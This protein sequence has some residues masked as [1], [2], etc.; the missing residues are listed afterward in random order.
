MTGLLYARCRRAGRG[1]LPPEGERRGRVDVD[2][3]H[4]GLE[5]VARGVAAEPHQPGVPVCTACTERNRREDRPLPPVT[6]SRTRVVPATVGVPLSRP[7]PDSDIPVGSWPETTL[8]D[9]GPTPWAVSG[10]EYAEPT[11]ASGTTRSVDHR[12]GSGETEH[13]EEARWP[14]EAAALVDDDLPGA[15]CHAR[16]AVHVVV[17]AEPPHLGA[18]GALQR[19]QVAGVLLGVDPGGGQ[20]HQVASDGHR[21]DPRRDVV[22]P[23]LGAVARAQRVQDRRA[24][25]GEVEHGLPDVD[26]VAVRRH[27]ADHRGHGGGPAVEPGRQRDLAR[28]RRPRRGRRPSRRRSPVTRS[29]GRGAPMPGCRWSGRARGSGRRTPRRRCCPPPR[30]RRWSWRRWAAAAARPAGRR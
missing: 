18:V 29:A 9:I 13:A 23:A 10:R 12:D 27:D 25:R 14:A 30:R 21:P 8:H 4:R 19:D 5:R 20:P 15:E 16:P 3:R 6:C 17:A 1:R 24:R 26:R 7:A 22:L 2:R 11:Y 28:L